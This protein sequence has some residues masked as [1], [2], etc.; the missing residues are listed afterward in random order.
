MNKI[1]GKLT[2]TETIELFKE[3][4]Y[5]IPEAEALTIIRDWIKDQGLEGELE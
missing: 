3:A 1:L 5:L 2:Q 4:I